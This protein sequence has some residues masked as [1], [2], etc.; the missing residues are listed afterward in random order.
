MSEEMDLE[1]SRLAGFFDFRM[2]PCEEG[3]T[4][5]F[6]G[7]VNFGS[8]GPEVRSG[9]VELHRPGSNSNHPDGSGA[10]RWSAFAESL[11]G[12]DVWRTCIWGRPC[13]AAV[14]HISNCR[15]LLQAAV[16]PRQGLGRGV[17][18]S[19]PCLLSGG[20]KKVPGSTTTRYV[21]SAGCSLRAG[22]CSQNVECLG[23]LRVSAGE[24]CYLSFF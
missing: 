6:L 18:V 11:P 4:A 22:R 9:V 5:G 8:G 23:R 24:I 3:L 7:G 2:R 15:R 19:G 16:F 13:S 1:L 20:R 12:K 17:C 21:Q 10:R 14:R